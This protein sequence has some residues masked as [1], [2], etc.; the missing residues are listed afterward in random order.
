MAFAIYFFN[1]EASVEFT[2][3]SL[4]TSAFSSCL[5]ERVVILRICLLSADKSVEFILPSRLISPFGFF[6]VGLGKGVGVRSGI[7][8]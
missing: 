8:V 6:G 7:G 4:F 5:P 2:E 3:P 1:I